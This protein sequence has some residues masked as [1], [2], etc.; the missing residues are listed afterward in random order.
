MLLSRARV[1]PSHETWTRPAG[2]RHTHFHLYS[3]LMQGAEQT[4]QRTMSSFSKRAACQNP[5]QWNGNSP[6]F[7]FYTP[8]PSFFI[9]HPEHQGAS[10]ECKNLMTACF[11]SI[12]LYNV[13]PLGAIM[14]FSKLLL[15]LCKSANHGV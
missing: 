5:W 4:L 6:H 7:L 3:C 15:L 1:I 12:A 10:R 2:C 14:Q 9:G 11:L 13:T 8:R